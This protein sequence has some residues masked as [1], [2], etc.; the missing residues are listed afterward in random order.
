MEGRKNEWPLPDAAAGTTPNLTPYPPRIHGLSN[1]PPAS[2]PASV[3]LA[4]SLHRAG[5]GWP[6]W[7]ACAGG[8]HLRPETMGSA[9]GTPLRAHHLER[10]GPREA[11]NAGRATP[12]ARALG[13]QGPH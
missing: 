2:L 7:P 9:H 12:R 6:G 13:L 1:A 4:Q 3:A 8:H 10:S 5:L 11:S